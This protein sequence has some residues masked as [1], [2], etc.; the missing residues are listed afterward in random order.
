MAN[1]A[2][3]KTINIQSL[4]KIYHT[5]NSSKQFLKAIDW[6]YL[7]KVMGV[8]S[9]NEF[10]IYLYILKWSGKKKYFFSPADIQI[11]LNIGEDT[12]RKAFKILID[13]GFLKQSSTNMY[14]F[15]PMPENFDKIYNEV[16]GGRALKKK[17]ILPPDD[18]EII[19]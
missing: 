16:I 7:M 17:K 6:E 18:D 15:D 11:R 9:G 12:A 14:E 2:N 5:P 1:Y 19:T 8:L 13:Y 3:Q 10:K 4:D